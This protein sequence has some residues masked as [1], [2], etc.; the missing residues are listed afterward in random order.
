MF[1]DT[2]RK[3]AMDMMHSALMTLQGRWDR[4]NIGISEYIECVCKIYVA[5]TFEEDDC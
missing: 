5:V 1:E 3:Q 4:G 2:I